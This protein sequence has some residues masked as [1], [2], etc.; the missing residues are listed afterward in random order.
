MILEINVLFFAGR[1]NLFI[2]LTHFLLIS[3]FF[4]AIPVYIGGKS[5][6]KK[7]HIEI[8]LFLN[9]LKRFCI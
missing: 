6:G 7:Q 2:C 9:A 8:L 4:V 5:C 3:A 1:A